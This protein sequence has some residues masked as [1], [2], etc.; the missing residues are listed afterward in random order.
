M[1]YVR[2]IHTRQHAHHCFSMS[3]HNNVF[4]LMYPHN[5]RIG[6]PRLFSESYG[7]GR[8]VT[9]DNQPLSDNHIIS[10]L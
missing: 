10:E 6:T 2:L 3:W 7:N 1:P 8:V 4:I 5:H 9:I